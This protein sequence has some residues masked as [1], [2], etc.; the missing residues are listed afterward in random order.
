M[1]TTDGD[2]R[3]TVEDG[4]STG[5]QLYDVWLLAVATYGVGDVVTTIAL[6]WFSPDF[7]EGDLLIAA[8]SSAFGGGGVL[9]IKLLAFFACMGVSLWLATCVGIQCCSTAHRCRSGCRSGVHGVEP[10]ADVVAPASG[11]RA[12][13][14]GRIPRSLRRFQRRDRGR[15][16][17]E[18]GVFESGRVLQTVPEEAIRTDVAHPD[19]SDEQRQGDLAPVARCAEGQR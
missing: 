2:D 12:A 7:V 19:Q 5:K 8:A 14:S 11:G 18:V 15:L 6:V 1:T 17:R 10:L 9:S 13:A 16:S 4:A 3:Y